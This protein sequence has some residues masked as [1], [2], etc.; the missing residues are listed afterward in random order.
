MM[1]RD[2]TPWLFL[3]DR[4]GGRLLQITQTMHGRPH[5]D[6]VAGLENTWKEHVKN[7]PS[8]VTG[9]DIHIREQEQVM[10]R[11]GKELGAWLQ[12][13]IGAFRIERVHMFAEPRLIGELRKVFPKTLN[14]H[15]IEHES[16]LAPLKNDELLKHPSVQKIIGNGSVSRA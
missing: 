5:L 4:N 10:N 12:Q 2:K 8:V 11:F 13:Q 7:R 16:E 15:V 1:Q 14:G 3:V 6:E 9:K